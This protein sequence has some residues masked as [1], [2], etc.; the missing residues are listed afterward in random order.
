MLASV[1]YAPA[2]RTGMSELRALKHLTEDVKQKIS[3]VLSLRGEN[4]SQ[5]E[6]FAGEWGDFPFWVDSSRFESDLLTPV[7]DNL[8]IQD[9]YFSNKFEL[10]KR[11]KSL[12][13]KTLPVVGFSHED[14]TRNIVRFSQNLFSEFDFVGIRVELTSSSFQEILTRVDAVLSALSDTNLSKIY[15]IID[16]ATIKNN[17]KNYFDNIKIMIKKINEYGVKN[18]ITLSSSFSFERPAPNSSAYH[19]CRDIIWQIAVKEKLNQTACIAIYGD[20]AATNPT[21]DLLEYIPGM[22]PIPYAGYFLPYEWYVERRG[23]GGEND[24]FREIA[25]NFRNLDGYHGDDFCWGNKM[26]KEIADGTRVKAGNIS[27]WNQIRINQ[28]ITTI[29]EEI[30]KGN[31]YNPSNEDDVDNE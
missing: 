2:L 12:N 8:N 15:L 13:K 4:L 16:L 22:T 21:K 30:S 7:A 19:L 14:S 5:I 10:F 24:K 3:P 23:A 11:I 17:V 31:F 25:Q 28:H 26:I 18:V 6:S 27:F 20:Y 9:N 1:V 29:V